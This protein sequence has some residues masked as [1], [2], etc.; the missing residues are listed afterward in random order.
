MTQCLWRRRAC[1]DLGSSSWIPSISS[2]PQRLPS[3]ARLSVHVPAHL[4]ST[5][6]TWSGLAR[7]I[8][9]L[10]PAAGLCAGLDFVQGV[11]VGSAVH[12]IS[13]V[14]YVC[15]STMAKLRARKQSA[16]CG[17]SRCG[18]VHFDVSFFRAATADALIHCVCRAILLRWCFVGVSFVLSAMPT[19]PEAE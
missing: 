16:E 13:H 19:S 11:G 4:M 3:P 12:E 15:V 2:G 17:G 6:R 5:T 18:H 1:S 8:S 10:W 7:V 14:L 9:A